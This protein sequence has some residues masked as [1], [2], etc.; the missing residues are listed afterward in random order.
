MNRKKKTKDN[1]KKKMDD[2]GS[3][4][5][6]E[7]GGHDESINRGEEDVRLNRLEDQSQYTLMEMQRTFGLS[8]CSQDQI[9]DMKL[10][11]VENRP[12]KSQVFHEKKAQKMDPVQILRQFD[13][14]FSLLS[15]GGGGDDDEASSQILCHNFQAGG[16]GKDYTRLFRWSKRDA[17]VD[18]FN[19]IHDQLYSGGAADF[20]REPPRNINSP[21]LLQNALIYSHM[22]QYLFKSGALIGQIEI[23][24]NCTLTHIYMSSMMLVC[25]YEWQDEDTFA[26]TVC[27][28]LVHGEAHQIGNNKLTVLERSD[29]FDDSVAPI[30]NS[31]DTKS[32]EK[33]PS[34]GLT[35][36]RVREIVRDAKLSYIYYGF[37]MRH[38]SL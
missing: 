5:D 11:I 2:I 30:R 19:P 33:K 14:H 25:L 20:T 17:I 23:L 31:V 18:L 34:I 15:S 1:Y 12:F 28:S 7:N 16:T 37:V 6:D 9:D 8:Q 24:L 22:G 21:F 35:M 38:S 29:L 4:D 27:F 10:D 3:S 13:T 26:L 32:G 36:E